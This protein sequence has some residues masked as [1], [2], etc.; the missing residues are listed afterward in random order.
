MIENSINKNYDSYACIMDLRMN[1]K[2][3]LMAIANEK[4]LLI[5][6]HT[7]DKRNIKITA[8]DVEWFV[9]LL[10]LKRTGRKLDRYEFYASNESTVPA[11]I[12]R[13]LH[14]DLIC[15]LTKMHNAMNV[16]EKYVIRI[17]TALAFDRANIKETLNYAIIKIFG[18]KCLKNNSIKLRDL[19]IYL[20]IM[21]YIISKLIDRDEWEFANE[22][23]EVVALTSPN[24]AVLTS[25]QQS[26]NI[27]DDDDTNNDDT[28]DNNGLIRFLLIMIYVG[29]AVS[30]T[31]K[32]GK[33][34]KII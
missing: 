6:W 13:A 12:Q 21:S 17:E 11:V 22:L 15:M 23:A 28:N 1:H 32:L 8:E 14:P 2:Q 20:H 31:L 24:S 5:N 19:Y 34:F 10:V 30:L 33:Y 9:I 26:A 4:Y 18:V 7:R 3:E 29:V 25:D 16:Y 27:N